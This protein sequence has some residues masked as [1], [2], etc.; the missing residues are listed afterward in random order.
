M[1]RYTIGILIGN[2]NSPHTKALMRGIHNA[3]K[4]LNVN[5][6][7]YLGVHMTFY[8]RE[9]FGDDME[10]DYDYQYNVVYDY[11]KLGAVDAVI[12]S[13]GS[14]CIFLEDK[15]KEHF[16]N[17]FQGIP[18]VLL[19]DRD[20]SGKGTSIISDN[21]NGMYRI[22]EHL[23]DVHG[24]RLM[25]FLSGPDN[26][27]D[28][29]E[30]KEA[31]LMAMKNHNLRV[32]EDMIAV[33]D[34]SECVE[35]QVNELLDKYPH[36]E[37]MVCAND[38][39]AETAY[40]ECA[41]RGLTVGKDIAITG[42]DDWDIAESM[43]PPLTTVLQ[44]EFDMGYTALERAIDLCEGKEPLS[45][46]APAVMKIR[47]SC[48][49]KNSASFD[50]PQPLLGNTKCNE[51][52]IENVVKSLLS[53]ILL[54]NVNNEIREG[55]A[56][57]LRDILSE[58]IILYQSGR[59]VQVDKKRLMNQINELIV[60]KY[61]KYV[62]PV[63]VADAVSAYLRHIIQFEFDVKK[64]AA[65]SD[66]LA[67][68]QQY[69]QTSIIKLN[70]DDL[71]DFQQDAMFMPLISR[72]MMNHIGD[73][74]EFYRAPMRILSSMR[75]RS[76]YLYILEKPVKHIYG[77]KWNCP[78]KL[79]LASYHEKDKI[80]SYEPGKRPSISKEEGFAEILKREDGYI[81]SG[82][83]L[84][85][86]EMQYGIL[87]SEIHPS[88]M[89][90]LHL[91]SMQISIALNFH[92]LYKK[93]IHTQK[94][95]GN[96]LEE[97]NEKNR[98][99]GFISEYD[100]L[101]GCLNRRGFMERVMQLTHAS[102]GKK[103][104]AIIGDLDHLKEINDCFGHIEGDFAIKKA[105]SILQEAVGKKALLARIGGDEFLAF[106]VTECEDAGK[107]YIRKI[108]ELYCVFNE[109][110][111]KPYYVEIS[112]GYADF[113]CD[114]ASDFNLLLKDSDAM[115]YQAKK[116]RRSSIVRSNNGLNVSDESR[117]N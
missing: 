32:E 61:G 102:E 54:S 116:T 110:S 93:Q 18:Y 35:E 100:E 98:I 5:V 2:A 43:T 74:V 95:L 4:R 111:N 9:Y 28:A 79:S 45:L 108:K 22:V 44:N 109:Q 27:T 70:K 41:K 92:I 39:M 36:M 16:M 89:I 13:Y 23:A 83:N 58:N 21:F 101:T 76:S 73:E 99:L 75:P 87:F 26:N 78:Q 106:I 63:M 59:I 15:N 40:R 107:K 56:T 104:V 90:L 37:A 113:I 48:G 7:F 34:F 91:A 24:Y 97:V 8:Y 14:L 31:F 96:A 115:L 53:K 1:R 88:D 64:I 30:R 50:F 117:G 19:E 112:V 81:M 10:N 94:K 84:Y 69:I 65:I 85:L 80:V 6:I 114:P 60:G 62:S 33:G 42:Y 71:D 20:E 67:A 55:V 38:V 49:C 66:I 11:A 17:R 46:I 57:Q 3:A 47:G 77:E 82:F 105:A 52:Y 12:V 103:A 29:E 72:D 25:T 86:G 68:I 51:I